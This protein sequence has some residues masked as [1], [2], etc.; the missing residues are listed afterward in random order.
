MKKPPPDF[1]WPPPDEELEQ[2][3]MTLQKNGLETPQSPV[4]SAAIA[5]DSPRTFDI[6]AEIAHLQALI[7]E[8]TQK[9][10]W[11]IN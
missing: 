10:E 8:L 7:E 6:T 9:V 4:E 2:G 11:R 1:N 5:P 3:F